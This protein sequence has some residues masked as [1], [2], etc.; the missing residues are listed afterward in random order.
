MFIYTTRAQQTDIF[1]INILLVLQ[2]NF[3]CISL[4]QISILHEE[5]PTRVNDDTGLTEIDRK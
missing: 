5:F 1:S 2:K 4:S 3:F